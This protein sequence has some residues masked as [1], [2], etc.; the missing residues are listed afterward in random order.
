MVSD[1]TRHRI[2]AVLRTHFGDAY[3]G[4][5]IASRPDG[6]GDPAIY[7]S[8]RF[9]PPGAVPDSALVVD[10]M[11][12]LRDA[13]LGNDDPRFPYLR[14]VYPEEPASDEAA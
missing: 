5:E 8:A 13:L 2:E 3:A 11:V 12:A 9:D 4:S 6:D 10:A 14:P 1:A 7:I